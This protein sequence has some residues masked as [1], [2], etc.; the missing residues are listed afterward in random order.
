MDGT[1]ITSRRL[2]DS[3][4]QEV[5]RRSARRLLALIILSGAIVRLLLWGHFKG[6]TL[7][8]DE[9]D[10]NAIAVHLVQNGQFALL[11]GLR[12]SI[13]PPLYP[14]F[15]AGIYEVCG[16]QNFQA[17]RLVQVAMSLVN[18]LL[19][20]WL[21]VM[22]FSRRVA[23]WLSAIYGFYPTLLGFNNLLMSEPLFIFLT[24]G[25]VCLFVLAI[26]NNSLA[27]LAAGSI[28]LGLAALTRSVLWAFPVPLSIFLLLAW[29]GTPMRRVFAVAAMVLAFA[30]TLAPWSIRNS[31]LEHTFTIVDTMG[32]RNFMMGNYRY[33]AIYRAWDGVSLIGTDHAWYVELFADYPFAQRRTQ[34]MLDKLATRRAARFIVQNP[35]LT[36]KRNAIKCVMFWG[37]ERELLA[38]T[39]AGYFGPFSTPAFFLLSA[40]IL[41]GCSV[42]MV[43][44]IFGIL[45]APPADRR[46][47]WLLLLVACFIWGIH[48]LVFGHSRYHLPALVMLLPFSASAL[49]N[50]RTIWAQRSRLRFRIACAASG[51]LIL[52]W[53]IEVVATD[54]I[55][56]LHYA[57]LS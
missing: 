11:P 42:V 2:E 44:A 47:F 20:Y 14:V 31:R 33:T 50:V 7:H 37:L 15:V 29:R 41:A 10:Y 3:S 25:A 13:R 24:C 18:V 12:T 26:Q 30:A 34:G 46:I 27:A 1:H 49:A 21:G 17:V 22:L 9:R 16:L 28:V 4:T 56:F 5:S 53:V 51:L 8:D 52:S 39:A 6:V 54:G 40:V 55:R 38:Q 36:I 23:L 57:H 35:L 48:T 32:G 43:A 45:L 19:M